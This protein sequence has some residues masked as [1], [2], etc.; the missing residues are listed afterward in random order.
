MRRINNYTIFVILFLI[1]TIIVSLFVELNQNVRTKSLIDRVVSEVNYIDS[2]YIDYKFKL[3]D[4]RDPSEKIVIV[5]IDEKS[6]QNIGRWQSWDRG[7][8]SILVDKLNELGAKVIGFDIVFDEKDNNAAWRHLNILE[9]NYRKYHKVGVNRYFEKMISEGIHLSD[10]DWMLVDSVKRFDDQY[11]SVVL[12]YF[13]GNNGTDPVIEKEPN[14][15]KY[16]KRSVIPAKDISKL[17]LE[18]KSE[19]SEYGLNYSNL[20]K[21]IS[22]HGYFSIAPD[23]DGVI[24]NYRLV[25]R[26]YDYVLPSLGLKVLEKFW[27]ESAVLKMKDNDEVLTINFQNHKPYT[28]PLA[29]SGTVKINYYGH[30]HSFITVSLSDVIGDE[31]NL[32]YIDY[33]GKIKTVKKADIFKDTI[34]LVGATATGIYDV[35]NTPVQVN[36][37]GVEIHANLIS[38]FLDN[39]FLVRS[40][41]TYITFLILFIILALIISAGIKFL[42]PVSSIA[43]MIFSLVIMIIF[44]YNF[45]FLNNKIV[46]ISHYFIFLSFL[47]LCLSTYHYLIE[48][49]E[50]KKIKSTFK[51]Y[52]SKDLVEVLLQ[53][54][55]KIKLGGES[56]NL[57]VMFSDIENFTAM[58]E[59]LDPAKLTELLNNYLDKMSKVILDHEGTLDKFIGDSIM[60]FWGAP[61]D[62]DLHAQKA[63]ESALLM[64]QVELEFNKSLPV[65][66]YEIRTRIGIN[67][68]DMA[69]G[70]M[71]SKTQFSYTVV[72]DNVNLASRLESLN[73]YYGTYMIVAENTY[74]LVRDKFNFRMLDRVAVKGKVNSVFIY[75]L[76]VS[77]K[78]V[79]HDRYEKALVLYQNS[80]FIRAIEILEKPEME[81]DGP[82]RL[83]A[84]RCRDFIEKKVDKF[85]G[86]WVFDQK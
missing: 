17:P 19:F 38:M 58:S 31:E 59:K 28:L 50:K 36:M 40:F 62:I 55:E 39:S 26:L 25:Q 67:T 7:V 54:P 23:A 66:G 85:N 56:K 69:V 10:T 52:V 6:L 41:G 1:I 30:Q 84:Q 22:N 34:V 14:E 43:I 71:G 80:E 53:H 77:E 9:N 47:Y 16:I 33:Y 78:K 45:L 13:V 42:S 76:L 18:L 5:A 20:A 63:C 61:V 81:H 57:T 65:T 83:I 32:E 8:Y 4:N 37:P 11:R 86:I 3:R 79:I 21:N 49:R 48:S 29:K 27:N 68:G 73:K 82:S 2:K 24:R 72:G 64:H 70:N 51:N 75:E 15:F 44:D 12:G 35:R 46:T 74:K 60:S